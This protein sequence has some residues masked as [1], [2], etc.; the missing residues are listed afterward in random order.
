MVRA[1]GPVASEATDLGVQYLVDQPTRL[2]QGWRPGEEL[3]KGARSR[4][5]GLLVSPAEGGSVDGWGDC[6]G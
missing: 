2:P 6:L 3:R 5:I 1:R 4:G